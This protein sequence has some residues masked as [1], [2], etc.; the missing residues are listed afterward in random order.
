MKYVFRSIILL[1]IELFSSE[2]V[3]CIVEMTMWKMAFSWLSMIQLKRSDN[4]DEHEWLT[5]DAHF[6]YLMFENKKK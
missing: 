2:S 1:S 4:N 5:R 6:E 3:S